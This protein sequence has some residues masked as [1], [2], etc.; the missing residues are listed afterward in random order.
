MHSINQS[1]E[2]Q[3][4]NKINRGKKQGLGSS[5]EAL[6]DILSLW[7]VWMPTRLRPAT[8]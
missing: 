5:F 6:G 3:R 7:T 1:C 4:I 2:F 8:G